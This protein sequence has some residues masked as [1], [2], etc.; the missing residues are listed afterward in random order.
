MAIQMTTYLKGKMNNLVFYERNGV[1]VARVMGA[2]PKHTAATK[3]RSE[4]FGICATLGKSL[5]PLLYPAI[6]F[7]K[8]KSM[9]G[10]FSGAFAKWLGL[11]DIL[12]IPPTNEIPFVTGFP[13]NPETSIAERCKVPFAVSH[14]TANELVIQLPAFVPSSA[15][16]A[17]ANT[18]ALEFSF[19]AASCMLSNGTAPGGDVKKI[20]IP[21][22]HQTVNASQVQ[23]FINT[24]PGA[25]VITALSLDYRLANGLLSNNTAFMPSAVIDARFI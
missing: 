12:S 23:L 5:R 19:A 9:Q 16:S 10:K 24:E 3:K 15:I 8:N 25:I 21:Y 11:R 13:F 20:I 2:A 7:P 22:D 6:P 4:N 1:Q 18:I 14:T 17:P